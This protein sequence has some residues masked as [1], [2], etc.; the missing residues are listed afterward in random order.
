MDFQAHGQ[1]L[2]NL[3]YLRLQALAQIENIAPILHGDGNAYGRLAIEVHGGI[4]GVAVAALDFGNI[5]QTEAPGPCL[6]RQF[7]DGL[8]IL[9]GP[10]HPQAHIVRFRLHHARRGHGASPRKGFADGSGRNAQL[11]ELLLIHLHIDLFLL[12]SQQLYL[13][14]GRV[15]GHEQAADI[16]RP[17]PHFLIGIALPRNGVD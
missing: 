14:D 10:A 13:L 3:R 4:L 6:H 7:P 15:G 16:L 9:E 12:H 2:G 5:P 8:H 17:L 1:I 11:G